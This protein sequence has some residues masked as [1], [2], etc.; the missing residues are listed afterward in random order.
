MAT[1]GAARVAVGGLSFVALLFVGL[2]VSFDPFHARFKHYKQKHFARPLPL[3][4]AAEPS[5]SLTV[6]SS[7]RT[8]AAKATLEPPQPA[9]AHTAAS[10]TAVTPA[11]LE[12]SVVAL[13]DVCENNLT[14]LEH[15]EFWGALV[16]SA[17]QNAVGSALEC[18]R[19]CRDYE[20]SVEIQGGKPCTT[21]V[22]HPTTKACWLKNTEKREHLDRP[23]RGPSIPWTS[24]ILPGPHKPCDDCVL[25]S[26]YSG[27]V[28]K[29]LCNT[30]REC[31]SPAIDGYAL[32]DPKCLER[33]REAQR[34]L[35]LLRESVALE[36]HAEEGA[37]YDGLGVRWGIGHKKANWSACE[38]ACRAH[39]P[40][41][42]GPFGKLPCNVWTWC[43][44]EKCW[45]P[46]AHSHSFGDCWCARKW[47][48]RSKL[49]RAVHRACAR[50]RAELDRAQRM[51]Q[52][53]RSC[54]APGRPVFALRALCPA[55]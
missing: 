36:A 51:R 15:T 49:H 17:D 37:D 52:A 31:G 9:L 53:L 5:A 42:S 1:L 23:G 18:C 41:G 11:T 26:H 28:S 14:Y 38:E 46:D 50:A 4:A 16:M 40:T 7:V 39:R 2:N 54:H 43:G 19:T 47:A 10:P 30:S 12:T 20:P 6:G 21:F 8:G 13:A 33:S 35:G 44:R 34:Y 45:E 25:P 3:T 48:E 29:T 32:V 27:C 55:M 24:G 22:Y